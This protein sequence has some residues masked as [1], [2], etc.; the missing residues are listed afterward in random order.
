[1][2]LPSQI[3]KQYQHEKQSENCTERVDTLR[4]EQ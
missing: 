1:M 3:R 2:Y 4:L